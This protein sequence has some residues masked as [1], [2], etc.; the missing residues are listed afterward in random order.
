LGGGGRGDTAFLY[1][2]GLGAFNN[3][4]LLD[5][6]VGYAVVRIP[7]SNENEVVGI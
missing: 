5:T 4:G 2:S 1:I 3:V 6:K 7:I